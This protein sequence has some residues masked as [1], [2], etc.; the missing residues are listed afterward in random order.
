MKQNRPWANIERLHRLMAE[1]DL[2]AVVVRSGQNVTYLS[3]VVYPGTLARHLDLSDSRRGVLVVWPREAEPVFIFDNIAA[4][5]SERD[6]CINK[7]HPFDGFNG[8]V[9]S[10][11]IEVV[12]EMGL[13][14]ARVGLESNCIGAGDWH[15]VQ[16]TLPQ[17]QMTDCTALMDRVRWI[18]TPQEVA[19][20]KHAA[21]ILDRCYL[22]VFPSIRRGETERDVHARLIGA[23]IKNGAGWAHGIF[24]SSRNNTLYCGE[25]DT[26]LERGDVICTDYV[27]YVDGYPGHQNRNAV[28]GAATQTQRDTY[29]RYRELYLATIER[30]RTGVRV[31]DLFRETVASFAAKGWTYEAGL[32]GHSVGPWWHQQAPILTRTCEVV[33]ETGMVL[34]I[35]PFVEYWHTQ[36]LVLL[37]ADGPEILSS[38][39]DTSELMVIGD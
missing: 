6:S 38:T 18:K 8:D 13:A 30:C 39:F 36:D 32:I 10:K 15:T 22:D 29:A 2:D 9:F 26:V 37:T 33:L 25:G 17:L 34:A 23:C 24:N 1:E 28:I 27:A 21:D 35:E 12:H 5:P 11:L 31:S 19:C 7:L 16:S 4:G 14:S 3:G 20:I